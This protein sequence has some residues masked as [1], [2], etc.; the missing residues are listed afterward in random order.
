MKRIIIDVTEFNTWSGHLTGVQRVVYNLAKSLEK[1]PTRVRLITYRSPMIFEEVTYE[2]LHEQVNGRN[3]VGVV[4][5]DSDVMNMKQKTK[6]VAKKIYN[7]MPKQIRGRLT[8]E[9]KLLLKQVLRKGYSI[10]GNTKQWIKGTRRHSR[11]IIS[12]NN[13]SFENDDVI[14]SAGRAWDDKNYLSSLMTIKDTK[15]V[16]LV[17]IVY[18]LI[19][20]YQQHTFG[21]G[22][23]D[24]YSW[25]LYNILKSGDYLLPISKAT[26]RDLIKYAHEIGIFELPEMAVIRLGDDIQERD[27]GKKPGFIDDDDFAI[28]VGTIEARKNHLELYYAYKLAAQRKIDL[29]HMYIIGKPG[30]LTHDVLYF[31]QHDIEVKDKVSIVHSVSDEE[32]TWM[33]KNA[34]F[35][36]YTSQ[37]EGWGL[38]VAESLAFGTPCITSNTSSMA[39]IA[40]DI[41]NYVSPYDPAQL[42][43]NM[44]RYSKRSNS[45]EKR[46]EVQKSYICHPWSEV[47][48]AILNII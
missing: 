25:Y 10:Y 36:V 24:R 8:P 19:P 33:Y 35:T 17:Y 26:E 40:P 11:I 1:A 38:P 20:I 43:D 30:W 42:L 16:K 23:T 12:P 22:L 21:P 29:A 48:K 5:Q 45:L 15:Q 27:Q 41:A 46:Q 32:L 44:S 13:F 4:S 39:E 7:M 28:S 37:Y 2:Y 31:F 34:L 3:T 47:A 6:L 14:V 18:D 9:R